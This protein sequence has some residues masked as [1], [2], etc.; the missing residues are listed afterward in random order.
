MKWQVMHTKMSWTSLHHMNDASNCL[1]YRT[2]SERPEKNNSQILNSQ[3]TNTYRSTN[4]RPSGLKMPL[5]ELVLIFWV[6]YMKKKWTVENK[7]SMLIVSCECTYQVCTFSISCFTLDW[8]IRTNEN[9]ARTS[10]IMWSTGP[11]PVWVWN[12]F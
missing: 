11:G 3:I 9:F 5:M 8:S 7:D 2:S 4:I 12:F 6:N 1:V 10:E